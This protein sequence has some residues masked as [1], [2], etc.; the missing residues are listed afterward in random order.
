M[1]TITKLVQQRMA[2][3]RQKQMTLNKLTQPGWEDA[4]DNISE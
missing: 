3:F 2:M 4:A 1:G